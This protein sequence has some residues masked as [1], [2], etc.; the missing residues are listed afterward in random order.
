M[1]LLGHCH[2]S[3]FDEMYSPENALVGKFRADLSPENF[4]KI[5]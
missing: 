3:E 5:N 4:F 1:K 2:L